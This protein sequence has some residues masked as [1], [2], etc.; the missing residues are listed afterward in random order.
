MT[1]HGSHASSPVI[2]LLAA[3]EGSRYRG[4]KQL[5]DIEHEPMVR[6][7]ARA[8]LET[9]LP[10]VVVTGAYAEKVESVIDD[11]P[12]HMVRCDD[13]RL[14]MGQSLATGV[15]FLVTR[16]PDASAVLICLADQPLLS[17]ASLQPLLQRHAQAPERL[18]ATERNGVSGPPVLFPRDCFA[19]LM[20]Q[21][22]PRGARTVLENQASRVEAFASEETMDVDT[23]GDLERVQQWLADIN[24]HTKMH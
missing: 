23:P 18:L 19:P 4:I 3:G 14:G 8:V 10:V 11:L 17:S 6:R 2:L 22:G 16:F 15:R 9:A 21:S 13:W 5:A 20:S 12:L 24:L 7:V 1:Q